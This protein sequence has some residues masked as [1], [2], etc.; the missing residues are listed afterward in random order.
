MCSMLLPPPPPWTFNY[1]TISLPNVLLQVTLSPLTDTASV[2][3]VK[4]KSSADCPVHTLRPGPT[5][6]LLVSSMTGT[7]LADQHHMTSSKLMIGHSIQPLTFIASCYLAMLH[8]SSNEMANHTS[9]FQ[10][11][12]LSVLVQ[13]HWLK[14]QWA[15]G[16]P[17]SRLLAY[18]LF[19]HVAGW[20]WPA[21]ITKPA[22]V[23]PAAV[24][25]TTVWSTPTAVWST[26]AAVWATSVWAASVWTASL[27]AA[28]ET[29]WTVWSSSWLPTATRKCSTP[30]W[31]P[32][33]GS[34]GLRQWPALWRL[35]WWPFC[36]PTW[37]ESRLVGLV[38]GENELMHLCVDQNVN[39]SLHYGEAFFVCVG[40]YAGIAVSICQYVLLSVCPVFFEQYFLNCSTIFNQ[41]W[42]G[43]VLLWGGVSSRKNWFAIFMVKVTVRVYVINI[44]LFLSAISSELLVC[45]QPNLI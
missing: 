32:A 36:T 11:R 28:A 1:F 22:T 30:L 34:P 23:W 33:A 12:F 7:A 21:S 3:A 15:K 41:T 13:L 5:L 38:S 6:G 26:S 29:N 14:C 16:C 18:F 10:K 19:C 17:S 37:C 27:R 43:G 25:S 8:F 9:A 2:G 35:W 4:W 45:L 39:L 31:C 20:I 44:W 24:R 42:Y 40:V